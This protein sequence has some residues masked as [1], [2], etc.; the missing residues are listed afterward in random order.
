MLRKLILC[1]AIHDNHGRQTFVDCTLKRRVVIRRF[2]ITCTSFAPCNKRMKH[3][4]RKRFFGGPKYG[5]TSLV[6]TPNNQNPRFLKQ[7]C[8]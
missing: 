1:Q 6:R 5:Q 7:N 2:R 3:Y 8:Y 4:L